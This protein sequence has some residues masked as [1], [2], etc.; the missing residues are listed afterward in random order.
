MSPHRPSVVFSHAR[1]EP[2]D[3]AALQSA[4]LPG[5]EA[6]ERNVKRLRLVLLP[7]GAIATAWW[8]RRAGLTLPLALLVLGGALVVLHFASMLA[9]FGLT[10]FGLTRAV[11]RR[12]EQAMAH[13]TVELTPT[14]VALEVVV[15]GERHL[16]PWAEVEVHSFGPGAVALSLA[17][18]ASYVVQHEH[19]TVPVSDETWRAFLALLVQHARVC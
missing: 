16:V 1:L 2:L 4:P 12:L 11:R 7:L 5:P 8:T 9:A 10:F 14:P 13:D 3:Q 17:D 6:L 18:G 15:G 19:L